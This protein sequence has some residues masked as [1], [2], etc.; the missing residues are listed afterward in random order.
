MTN[1]LRDYYYIIAYRVCRGMS[2]NDIIE[3]LRSMGI[4]YRRVDMLK[5]IRY[6]RGDFCKER[7]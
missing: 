4:G 2:S 5:D 7:Y 6:V 3:D 1:Y